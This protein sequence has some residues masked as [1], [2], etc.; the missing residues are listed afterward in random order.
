MTALTLWQTDDPCPDCGT[1]L[2]LAEDGGPVQRA[3]CC[4]C[5]RADTWTSDQRAGGDQ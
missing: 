4:S 5:G 2:T 1:A 3:E